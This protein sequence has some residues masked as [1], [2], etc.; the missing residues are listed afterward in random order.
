MA[1]ITPL[2][3]VLIVTGPPASGMTTLARRLAPMLGL[4]LLCKDTVKEVLFETLGWPDRVWSQRL[5]GASM[6]LLYTF[7]ETHLAVGAS[8]AVEANFAAQYATPAFRRLAER[9]AYLPIQVNCSADPAVLVERFRLRALSGERHPGHHD[10]YTKP[11]RT[12]VGRMEPLDIGGHVIECDATC[13]QVDHDALAARVR[14][15]WQ[16]PAP[17]SGE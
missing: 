5:G 6:E 17:R 1:A 4:P 12:I 7:V 3:L 9:Y 2:P 13:F 8:C 11:E 14:A 10:V 15:L 16:Q